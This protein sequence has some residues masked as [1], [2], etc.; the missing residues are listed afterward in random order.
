METVLFRVAQE[1]L[2]NIVRHAQCEEAELELAFHSDRV[3]LNVRDDG[4]GIRGLPEK[5]LPRG[6]GLEGMRER[7][8]SVEGNL[9]ISSPV[10]G[11]T[12]VEVSVPLSEGRE[13]ESEEESDGSNQPDVS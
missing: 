11:G 3:G 10:S 4:V 5:G 7:V 1:G 6:W 12:L 13:S 2:T 9:Q 8:E